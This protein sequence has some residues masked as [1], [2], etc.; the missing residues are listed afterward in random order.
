MSRFDWKASFASALILVALA[1]SQ[2]SFAQSQTSLPQR[3]QRVSREPFSAVSLSEDDGPLVH[4][5]QTIRELLVAD[6]EAVSACLHDGVPDCAPAAMLL[7]IIGEAKAHRGKAL[8]A[9]INRSINLLIRPAPGAWIGPLEV[10]TFADRN[11][12]DYSIAKF[13]ALREAGIPPERLRLVIVRNRRLSQDHMIVAAREDN[14]WLIL[15]NATMVLAADSEDAT[16]Y[17]PLF[18][19]DESGVRRY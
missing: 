8:I 5:W 15:D 11:C 1:Q 18:L 17:I 19:L 10:L 12:K 14:T 9:H 13:F 7:R 3:D 6:D 16:V 2:S 4:I